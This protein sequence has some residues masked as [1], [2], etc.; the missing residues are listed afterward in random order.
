VASSLDHDPL[1]FIERNLIAGAIIALVSFWALMA[2]D[3]GRMKL[4]SD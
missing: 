4:L 3:P 2:G 1:N